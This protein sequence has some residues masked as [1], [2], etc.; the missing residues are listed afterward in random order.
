MTR[1]PLVRPP[2]I[3]SIQVSRERCPQL[4]GLGKRYGAPSGIVVRVPRVSD[5]KFAE[6]R[7]N[8][9][10]ARRE[11]SVYSNEASSSLLAFTGH[12][13]PAGGPAVRVLPADA[14]PAL[15]AALWAA[16]APRGNRDLQRRG[17][18]VP[19]DRRGAG[20]ADAA[21]GAREARLPALRRRH[22]RRRARLRLRLMA[23]LLR[24]S[25]SSLS[26]KRRSTLTPAYPVN[27]S[28]E[29]TTGLSGVNLL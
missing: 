5:P 15:E 2:L 9:P 29:K 13:A 28:Y 23:P 10:R 4:H 26:H 14:S 24:L 17:P 27:V 6:R 16:S 20:A 1:D 7:V 8:R 25:A 3:R 21:E 12:E 22:R 18:R 11:T 19:G